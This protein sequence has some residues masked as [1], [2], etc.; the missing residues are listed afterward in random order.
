MDQEE[1]EFSIKIVEQHNRF[2]LMVGKGFHALSNFKL[3]LNVEV[4]I[5][6]NRIVM[7]FEYPWICVH[8]N[9]V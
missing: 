2:G 3:D 1:T 4:T 9:D 5:K 7:W 8:H 6:R